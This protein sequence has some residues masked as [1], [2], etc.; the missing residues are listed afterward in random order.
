MMMM[1]P[2]TENTQ[3]WAPTRDPQHWAP[4]QSADKEQG[5]MLCARRWLHCF[6]E[7]TLKLQAS[8][9]HETINAS[10][11]AALTS[12]NN[13]MS[14]TKCMGCRAWRRANYQTLL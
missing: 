6:P 5:A 11:L 1:M 8:A 4:A 10:G 2:C 14:V 7:P 12:A 9:S 13:A 3:W